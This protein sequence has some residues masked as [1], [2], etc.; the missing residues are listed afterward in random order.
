MQAFTHLSNRLLTRLGLLRRPPDLERHKRTAQEL[1]RAVQITR[2]TGNFME[3]GI[4]TGKWEG[5]HR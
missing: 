4:N 5:Q 2:E 1:K 3:D